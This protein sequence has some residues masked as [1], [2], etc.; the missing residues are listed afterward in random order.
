[1]SACHLEDAPPRPGADLRQRSV[2]AWRLVAGRTD[3]E[4][5]GDT[6]TCA[7]EHD[8]FRKCGDRLWRAQPVD[9]RPILL[10]D[11]KDCSWNGIHNCVTSAYNLIDALTCCRRGGRH[12]RIIVLG[13]KR[14]DEDNGGDGVRH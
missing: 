13:H 14:V 5:L 10:I 4:L 9:P 8:L 11:L 2:K 7:S 12:H 3:I 6:L 1:M